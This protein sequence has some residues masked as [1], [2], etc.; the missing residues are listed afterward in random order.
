MAT[1]EIDTERLWSSLEELGDIGEQPNGSMMRITGSDADKHAR[2]RVVEWFEAADLEVS[3][4]AVGNIYGRRSGTYDTAPV[5]SGSHLDTVPNGGKFDGTTGVLTA[6]EVI[7]AW[8]DAGIETERPIEVV[9]FTEEEGTRF[10]TGM[11]GSQVGAGVIGVDEALAYEDDNGNTLED[12]LDAIG[13]RGT[14]ARDLSEI[15]AFVEVHVEQGPLL[16]ATDTTIGV[17]EAITG[18]AH[19]N[20][21]FTGEANHAGTTAMDLRFDGFAGVAEVSMALEAKAHELAATSEAVGTIG[22]VEVDPGAA[23][24][25]PGVARFTLD[26]RDTNETHREVLKHYILGELTAIAERRGLDYDVEEYLDVSA[27]PLDTRV[28]NTI[29]EAAKSVGVDYRR[30][31]S[32]AAHDAMSVATV[33][34]AGMLFVPSEGGISHSPAEFTTKDDLSAGT[35]ALERALYN[36]AT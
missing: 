28:V 17:V 3:V 13:Y 11:L 10:G 27:T 9:V 33:A 18:L 15:E 20:V 16:E 19:Y 8:N 29:E 4:D 2:D 6:I 25:I 36:L 35:A 22:K 1:V 30:M 5:L 21:N 26:I 24:V 32:G 14:T 31:P 23:N 7:R 34:P 12:V